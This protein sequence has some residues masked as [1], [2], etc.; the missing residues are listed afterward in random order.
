MER[1]AFP[2]QAAGNW[3]SGMTL[4]EWYAGLAMQGMLADSS[5]SSA[6]LAGGAPAG[7]DELIAKR[8]FGI[9]DKMLGA[10]G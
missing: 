2:H 7:V 3:H 10:G 1:S 6:T 5:A 4:R 8:A 9:A